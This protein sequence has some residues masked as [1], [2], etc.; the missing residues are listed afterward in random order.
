MA[1]K[2]LDND[3]AK[4]LIELIK[5]ETNKKVDKETNITSFST[6]DSITISTSSWKD[7]STFLACPYAAFISVSSLA[8]S[9][10]MTVAEL[11]TKLGYTSTYDYLKELYIIVNV[12]PDN[13]DND[14]LATSI[15][16]SDDSDGCVVLFANNTPSYDVVLDKITFVKNAK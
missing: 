8:T 5:T 2:Y 1:N 15:G 14:I 7:D 6:A 9:Y 3:S 4:T 13:G 16:I 10:D 11:A 12:N